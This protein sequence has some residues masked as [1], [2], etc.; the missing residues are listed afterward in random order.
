M[1]RLVKGTYPK[2]PRGVMRAL[3]ELLGNKRRWIKG[4]Y[5]KGWFR[6]AANGVRFLGGCNAGD[7]AAFCFCL[8]GGFQRVCA[9]LDV[10]PEVYRAAYERLRDASW[11]RD[12]IGHND[13]RGT[14]HE[15][16]MALLRR[17]VRGDK[18]IGRLKAAA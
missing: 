11:Q 6:R 12:P 1:K 8:E 4:S 14:T 15:N 7:D 17:A 9:E 5:A 3:V 13:Y 10:T 18:F 16:L 2:T